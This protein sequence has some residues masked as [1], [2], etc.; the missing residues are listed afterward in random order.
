VLSGL[1]VV[2]RPVGGRQSRSS[3]GVSSSDWGRLTWADGAAGTFETFQLACNPTGSIQFRQGV[4]VIHAIQLSD[5]WRSTSR[6]L[7]SCIRRYRFDP[8]LLRCPQAYVEAYDLPQ[9]PSVF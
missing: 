5:R 1:A 2:C 7:S 9:R 6:S 4:P 8:V 3:S